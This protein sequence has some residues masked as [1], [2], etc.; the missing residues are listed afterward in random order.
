M[1]I[2]VKGADFSAIKIG[3]AIQIPDALKP[4]VTA[5]G[6]LSATKL[7]AL[8]G[9]Y[10]DM[11]NAGYWKR[12]YKLYVPIMSDKLETSHVNI[13]DGNVDWIPNDFF[14]V[15]EYGLTKGSGSSV[16]N[17]GIPFSHSLTD[18]ATF[19]FSVS[20]D[21]FNNSSRC[22]FLGF[23]NSSNARL[24]YPSLN[25]YTENGD[26]LDVMMQGASR[27]SKTLPKASTDNSTQLVGVNTNGNIIFA[28][29]DVYE[30][31]EYTALSGNV[32]K[33][34]PYGYYNGGKSDQFNGTVSVCGIMNAVTEAEYKELNSIMYAFQRNLGM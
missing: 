5:F 4:A 29:G 19:K 15:N 23:D 12:L 31:S 30:I 3:T 9:L 27:A 17:T 1:K 24:F 8:I 2:I 21:T 20:Q 7:T 6:T 34:H 13:I 10:N 11:N 32:T 26:T 22:G 18:I 28:S 33:I 25:H 14:A 16:V